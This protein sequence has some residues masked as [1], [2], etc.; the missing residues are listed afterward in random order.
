[1]KKAKQKIWERLLEKCSYAER[2]EEKRTDLER[3]VCCGKYTDVSLSMPVSERKFYVLGVGQL[4]EQCYFEITCSVTEAKLE[5][6]QKEMKLLVELCRSEEGE[7]P[8]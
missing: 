1:M 7:N 5:R 2:K 8:A 3:C 4:C 6:Q